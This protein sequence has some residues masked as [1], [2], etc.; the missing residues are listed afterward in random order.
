MLTFKD[1]EVFET[2][3]RLTGTDLDTNDS[4]D[5]SAQLDEGVIPQP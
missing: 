2:D 1:P 3:D 5:F 4:A